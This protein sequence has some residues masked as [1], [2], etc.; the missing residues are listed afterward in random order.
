MDKNTK[1]ILWSLLNVKN[2][3]LRQKKTEKESKNICKKS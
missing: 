2:K 3:C 1:I